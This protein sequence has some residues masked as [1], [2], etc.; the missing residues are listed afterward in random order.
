MLKALPHTRLTLVTRGLP[1][2]LEQIVGSVNTMSCFVGL[3]GGRSV[4]CINTDTCK[5]PETKCGLWELL[6][7]NAHCCIVQALSH[8]KWFATGRSRFCW[9]TCA[10]I[11]TGVCSTLELCM[12]LSARSVGE[13]WHR[14][15]RTPLVLV[16]MGTSF[17]QTAVQVV[18]TCQG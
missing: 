7:R 18:C 3:V 14:V 5:K 10:S 11:I 12:S 4:K 13:R 2:R 8:Q 6:M 16:D 9:K 15:S 1:Q 17:Y